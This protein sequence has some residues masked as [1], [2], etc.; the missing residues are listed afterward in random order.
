VGADSKTVQAGEITFLGRIKMPTGFF[1]RKE[2][3]ATGRG[4]TGYIQGD[5]KALLTVRPERERQR[6]N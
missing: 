4:G 5:L 3:A 6:N 1:K 2:F